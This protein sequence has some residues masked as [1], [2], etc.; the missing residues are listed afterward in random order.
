MRSAAVL[1]REGKYPRTIA[2]IRFDRRPDGTWQVISPPEFMPSELENAS[3][4]IELASAKWPECVSHHGRF[5]KTSLPKPY[6][7]LPDAQLFVFRSSRRFDGHPDVANL[8]WHEDELH[9]VVMV[10]ARIEN[11]AGG[12]S[13]VPLTF[14]DDNR[15]R[16]SEPDGLLPLFGMEQI[17]RHHGK[18]IAFV[19]EGAKAAVGARCIADACEKKLSSKD[20]AQKPDAE[21][22]WALDLV[23]GIHLGWIGG[24]KR[25]NATDWAF[26]K[27]ELQ[28]A[29]IDL[30]VIVGDNDE[31]GRRALPAISR[32]MAM[33]TDH[34]IF[35]STFPP[36][37]DL[38]DKMP[39]RAPAFIECCIPGTW[40]TTLTPNKRGK[41]T[42]ILTQ[43]GRQEW[44]YIPEVRLYV[45][46]RHC[47]LQYDRERLDAFLRPLSDAAHTSF[48]IEEAPY[49]TGRP[50]SLTYHPGRPQGVITDGD[51]IALNCHR[52]TRVRSVQGN[53]AP[54][55]EFIEYLFP[56]PEDRKHIERWCATLIARPDQR[57]IFGLL[58]ISETQGVGKSTLGNILS[59]LIG[60]HNTSFPGQADIVSDFNEWQY[61]KR[62]AVIN[63]VYAGQSWAGYNALKNAVTENVVTLNQKF[64]RQVKIP[65]WIH[66][67]AC[68]NSFRA[69]K[70]AADDRRWFVP[71]VIEFKWD[72]KKFAALFYWLENGGYGEIIHW[73]E[74]YGDYV[75]PGEAAP[76]SAAKEE[77]IAAGR[78]EAANAVLRLAETMAGASAPLAVTVGAVKAYARRVQA[79]RLVEG[80]QELVGL[81]KGQGIAKFGRIKVRG[82]LETV[83]INPLLKTRLIAIMDPGERNEMA[84]KSIQ[85]P[86]QICPTEM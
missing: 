70:L 79:G 7:R 55:L 17:H 29:G 30:V 22:P 39:A 86:D 60:P 12:K 24:A 65:N 67:L 28:Q 54:F 19:H 51:N 46:T 76:K 2:V 80:D 40:M 56:V 32:L 41:P 37:F 18:R 23:A 11:D 14:W 74:K 8:R 68:S 64:Q 77:V 48:L 52:P 35:P 33:P 63:E 78:T 84:V 27:K 53:A 13:Y 21:H 4:R 75:L 16:A 47:H 50:M 38:A 31:D 72:R 59:E 1:D 9:D 71:E 66:L 81:L 44:V 10:Q 25:A 6:S 82:A 20:P 61:Q 57:M 83:W 5:D 26:L 34:L 62:L 49:T 85:T 36:A 43:A 45:H 42:P 15:W 69:L 3:I 73:A 58:L